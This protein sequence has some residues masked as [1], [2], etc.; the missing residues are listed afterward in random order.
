M[1]AGLGSRYG[2][3]K[4]IDPV[5]P[6]GE[7][8]LDYAAYD[9]LRSGFERIVFV[10]REE[11][12]GD[13]RDRIEPTIGRHCNVR[14]VHQRIEDV[15]EG[16]DVPAMRRKPWGTGHAALAAE[17]AL[18]G[19]FALINADDFYGRAAFETVHRF[20]TRP[21]GGR[22]ILEMALVGYALHNTLTEHG[23]VARGLCYV[24]PD[25]MLSGIREIERI[26]RFGESVR[27]ADA[28]DRWHDIDPEA[29]VSMNMWGFP[30]EILGELRNRFD[31][32]LRD[33]GIDL[34]SEEFYL[35]DAVG[36]LIHDGIGTVRVLPTS[37]EW[38]GITYPEDRARVEERIR[39]LVS[40][41]VYPERLW[42]ED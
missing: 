17:A 25:G 37:E 26:R 3:V 24:G 5:G 28:E 16:I 10:I 23:S 35:P 30:R 4:Q 39:Q 42:P 31:V 8:L 1:A 6:G 21:P 14:Y 33:P 2:G 29:I 19:P 40:A 9:A 13:F 41:G 12:E 11:I 15:P 22:S 27:F 36:E 7:I 20:L 34:A 38:F 32:L 18:D